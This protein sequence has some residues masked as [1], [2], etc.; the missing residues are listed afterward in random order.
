MSI[1]AQVLNLLIDL[2]Q[3]YQATYVFL[4]H[5]QAVVRHRGQVPGDALLAFEEDLLATF[6]LGP[7]RWQLCR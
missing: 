1:Q 5:S 4:S 7:Y 2:Q 3:P 6:A